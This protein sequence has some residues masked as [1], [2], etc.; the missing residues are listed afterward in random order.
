MKKKI[1]KLFVIGI[2]A[3]SVMFTSPG[4][5]EV[6]RILTDSTTSDL[7][8]LLL[9]WVGKDVEQLDQL[10]SDIYLGPTDADGGPG[11]VS[12]ID[13]LPPIG[14]Q[15]RYGTCVAW[16][17]GYNH[18]TFLN[19]KEN[20]FSS[21]QLRSTQYQYSPKDL[22]LAIP[23]SQKGESCNG[24]SF[25]VTY[26]IMV[27]RGI[28]TMSSVPYSD[29]DDCSSSPNSSW[30]SEANGNKILNYRKISYDVNSVRS[31]LANGRL[32]SIGARLGDNF[33]K[34][35]DDQIIS[36]DTYNNPGMQHAYHAM[37]VAGYDDNR[38]AF[39]VVNSWSDRWGDSGYVW[40]DYDFFQEE[41]CFCAF[42]A[43]NSNA[44]PDEDGDN[45][46]DN[47]YTKDGYDLVGTALEDVDDTDYSDPIERVIYYNV[48][49]SGNQ[50]INASDDWAILYLYYNAYDAEDY[51]IMIFD[52]YKDDFGGAKGDMAEITDP[53]YLYGS[54]SNWWTNIDV[55]SG[56][57]VAES[58]DP[59]YLDF[60]FTYTMPN[61]SGKYFMVL[62][63]DG[64]D[65]I[66]ES[67]ETNNYAYFAQANG[68]P[69]DITNGVIQNP[70]KKSKYPLMLR[71]TMKSKSNVNTYSPIEIS[72][73]VKY[74]LE[75]G[76]LAKKAKNF[77]RSAKN[78]KKARRK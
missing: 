74:H 27:E 71:H 22:F 13:Y 18:R 7:T 24:T 65:V 43:T 40:V 31:Y 55:Q 14:D 4:C 34:W 19:A 3:W 26:D 64:F 47:D 10:E 1:V 33:M 17:L 61:I 53:T 58:A 51:G 44:N 37:V 73:M 69:L 32:V 38:N 8:N 41:F 25:E 56:K 15:G 16:A 72:K 36:S 45:E 48:L 2:T 52:Y 78:V 70:V 29:L 35:N 21:S 54:S 75:S 59:D 66:S 50:T 30:T 42:V 23:N 39:K 12:L 49:N 77:K 62:I 68:D 63:A 46:V 76:D 67:D 20:G 57:S 5:E 60:A 28:A 9:G 6:L 11:Q